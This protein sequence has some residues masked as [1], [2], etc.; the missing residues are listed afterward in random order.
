MTKETTAKSLVNVK[1][2]TG[3]IRSFTAEPATKAAW[4][5][6]N[7]DKCQANIVLGS[8]EVEEKVNEVDKV[9]HPSFP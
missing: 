1:L 4:I 3:T 2:F 7:W 5:I 8:R 6:S 9:P